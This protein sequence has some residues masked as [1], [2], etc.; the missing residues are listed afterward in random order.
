MKKAFDQTVRDIKREVN[1]KVL[2]VPSIEQKVLDATSNEPWGPHGSL[3][4]DIAQASRNYHEYQVIMAVIWKRINDTGKNWRHV[5]KAL[6][7]LDY[8]VPHGS[9][10]VID[11][12]REHAYQISTLSDFQYID[13]S[14]RDQGNNVR[15]KSQNIVVLVNDKERIQEVRQKAAANRDKYRNT[16]MGS[17]PGSYSSS[18]GYGDRYDYEGR[19][20]SRYDDYNGYERE[21]ESSYRSDDD[22]QYGSSRSADR[23]RDHAYKD[24]GQYSSS[25]D[26]KY[27]EQNLGDPPRYEEETAGNVSSLSHGERDRETSLASAPKASSPPA[28]ANPSY[29]TSAAARPPELAPPPAP[30]PANEN[31]FDEFDPRGSFSAVPSKSNDSPSASGGVEMNIHGSLSESFS[32]NALALKPAASSTRNSE[33]NASGNSSGAPAP[34]GTLLASTISNQPFD[35]PFGD[36]PFKAFPSQDSLPAQQQIITSANSFNS[37]SNQSSDL[38]QPVSRKETTEFG[39]TFPGTTYMPS[40]PS[41]MQL[42]AIPQSSQQE[43]S[44][45]DILADI[46]PQSESSPFVN[47]QTS[48]PVLPSQPVQHIGFSPQS[49]QPALQSGM[50]YQAG[51]TAPQAQTS[52]PAGIPAQ[53]SQPSSQMGFP[54]HGSQPVSLG[55]LPSQTGSSQA[56][57]QAPR[58]Q[59]VPLN[60]NIYGGYHP[61]SISTGPAAVQMVPQISSGSVAQ[62]SFISQSGSATLPSLMA[63]SAIVPQPSK[64]K[65]ETKSTVW[66]D[67]LSRGLVNLNISG[68]KT[69]SLADI[70]VDFDALNRKEK[71]M[72]KPATAMAVSNVTMGQAMGSGSGI[73]RAGALGPPSNPMMGSGMGMGGYGGGNQ[74]MS[75]RMGMNTPGNMGIGMNISM[76]RGVQMQQQTGF[77]PGSTMSGGY[78]P[79]MGPSNYGQQPYGGG[80][81]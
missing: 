68:S 64:D 22:Y 4:A 2:K 38:P 20:G 51:K 24:D 16:S 78:N 5:Y 8:M 56:G 27:S 76:G 10:R 46:F 34:A 15:K 17:Q 26:H 69:N 65:F 19:Y 58:G 50:L 49:Y 28:S 1:K 62:N 35:D 43:V 13:S 81:R 63:S 80:Y 77:P 47:S 48:N 9:E 61:Q 3:L 42:P 66:A 60:S 32:S 54:T 6:T 52:Q 74:P 40:D 75:I 44:T 25:V 14:G 36:G 53:Q 57:I 72:E 71:R 73:G 30:A 33:A 67:T 11:E 29:V 41:G 39:G 55:E 23:D 37:S 12:I 31:G 7:V 45:I 21:R 18:V 70:G 59:P 79:I